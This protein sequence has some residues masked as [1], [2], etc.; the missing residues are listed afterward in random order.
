MPR[1]LGWS[2]TAPPHTRG[3]THPEVHDRTARRGSPAHAGIDP[4]LPSQQAYRVRLPRTRGDRPGFDRIV[5]DHHVAPPHTR[6]STPGT[7]DLDLEP[8]GSPA[9]AGIDHTEWKISSCRFRLPRTRGDRPHGSTCLGNQ[10]LAPPHTRGST[11]R[12]YA[13]AAQ[14]RGSPAHAGINLSP[15]SCLPVDDRL[16]R[17]RGDRPLLALIAQRE[18]PA[19]PHTRG[20]TSCTIG[21]TRTGSGSPAHAGIDRWM[22]AENEYFDRLPRTR[23]DRP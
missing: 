4:I 6:G 3:S 1:P 18:L 8:V 15:P 22:L 12:G 14:E 17:T 21:S 19:P 16:P 10:K 20:S 9:H 23:G 5:Q 7:V 13:V 2:L 11:R